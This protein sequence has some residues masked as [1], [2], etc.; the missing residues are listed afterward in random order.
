LIHGL[1]HMRVRPYYLFQCDPVRGSEHFRTTI[2]QGI[3]LLEQLRGHTS[4][5]S[6][7]TYVIDLPGGGGKVPIGPMYMMHYDERSGRAILRNFQE[8]VFEYL[9]PGRD[10][11]SVAPNSGMLELPC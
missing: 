2:A 9:D 3:A 8:R 7:P 6:V 5:L 11:P 4:G 10:L 1:L